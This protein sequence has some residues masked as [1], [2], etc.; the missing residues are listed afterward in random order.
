MLPAVEVTVTTWVPIG[1]V[2]GEALEHPVIPSVT[3][4]ARTTSK[5]SK[6][7][8]LRRRNPKNTSAPNGSSSA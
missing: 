8:G 2:L 1:A 5:P 7:T 4:A 3:P 6:R